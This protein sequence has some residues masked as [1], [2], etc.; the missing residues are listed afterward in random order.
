[1]MNY[2]CDWE[3]RQLNTRTKVC[4]LRT[5]KFYSTIFLPKG[6]KKDQTLILCLCTIFLTKLKKGL[7]RIPG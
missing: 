6:G 3:H 5:H 4:H 1:M 2:T 7:I